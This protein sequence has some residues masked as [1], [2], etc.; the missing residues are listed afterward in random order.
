M[1]EV[2]KAVVKAF[3]DLSV[4]TPH[5]WKA[6]HIPALR[7]LL[8]A[9]PM[10]DEW[11]NAAIRLGEELS[12]VGPDGY[13]DMTSRQWLDWAL[14]ELARDQEAEPVGYMDKGKFMLLTGGASVTT[15]V[16]SHRAFKDDVALYS[17]AFLKELIY[18]YEVGL[19]HGNGEH[20]DDALAYM[21]KGS[22]KRPA[23]KSKR[24]DEIWRELHASEPDQKPYGYFQY[25][26]RLGAWVQNREK[27]IGVAFYTKPAVPLTDEQANL[28]INGRGEEGD[29]DYVEPTGD[30]YGLTDEDLVKLIRR[31]EAHHGI[32]VKP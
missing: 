2:Q 9:E 3:D 24:L 15:T 21:T 17:K 31:V 30:G 29:D 20:A 10:Q 19:K 5:E 8:G 12:S 14:S 25:D 13:Y 18:A 27:N 7:Q 16:T 4:L 32:G 26:I 22:D 28:F 6:V 11:K 23:G 1:N